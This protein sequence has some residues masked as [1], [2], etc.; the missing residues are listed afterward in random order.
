MLINVRF[1]PSVHRAP[2]GFKAV[3]N[4]VVHFFEAQFSSPVTVN[5]RVGYGEVA[6]HTLSHSPGLLGQSLYYLDAFNYLQVQTSLVGRASSADDLA[7]AAALPLSSPVGGDI[8]L[9]QAQAKALGLIADTGGLDGYIGFATGS[10]FDFNERNGIAKGKYDFFGEV[11]H[12]ISEVMGR[13]LLVGAPVGST[14]NGYSLLDLYHFS[15]AINSDFSGRQP[16]YFSIDGGLS[17][18]DNFNTNPR[19][20]FG[21]WANSAGADPFRAFLPAGVVTRVSSTDLRELDIL[22]WDRT[23]SVLGL[24]TS[25]RPQTL[26]ASRSLNGGSAHSAFLFNG[27]F[28]DW[29][30]KAASKQMHSG[31]GAAP[32]GHAQAHPH[33]TG[34][35]SHGHAVTTDPFV[36]LGSASVIEHH[37]LGWG[38]PADLLIA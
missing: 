5:I 19:G 20:D 10:K 38:H 2:A 23:S 12:E 16:G 17:A 22:G 36:G 4:S 11:A 26:T 1:D 8:W 29:S 24:T 34:A 35:A 21:D 31:A 15:S 7:A 37:A 6:G 25:A 32:H 33:L 30:E 14:P 9:S 28:E 3:V 27:G 13:F 18:L